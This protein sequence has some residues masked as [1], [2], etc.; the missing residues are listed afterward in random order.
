M[1]SVHEWSGHQHAKRLRQWPLIAHVA[2]RV[3]DHPDLEALILIGS[4]AKHTA[5]EA[6]DVDLVV[7]VLEGRFEKAW[8]DRHLLAPTNSLV[9]WDIRPDPEREIASHRFLSRNVVKVEILLATPSSGFQ[10]ADPTA[11]V[12]GEKS[13]TERFHRIPAIDAEVLRQYAEELRAEGV[14]PEVELCYGN[15]MRAIRGAIS[16]WP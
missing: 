1:T 5:D 11:V 4:F 12:V 3:R 7:A 10:L 2:E 6:S 9:A 13:V 16:R 8:A 15:L 14:L